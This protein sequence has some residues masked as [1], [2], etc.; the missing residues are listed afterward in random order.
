VFYFA[1]SVLLSLGFEKLNK[2]RPA[3]NLSL[4]DTRRT[5]AL[6]LCGKSK[7]NFITPNCINSAG[8]D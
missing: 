5:A 2:S 1:A 4:H 8:V 7:G 6:T 3:F